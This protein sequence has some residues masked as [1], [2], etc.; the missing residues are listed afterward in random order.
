MCRSRAGALQHSTI[1]T[2]DRNAPCQW[3]QLNSR[4]STTAGTDRRCVGELAVKLGQTQPST[5][6]GQFHRYRKR[7]S[8]PTYLQGSS[9]FGFTGDEASD[10]YGRE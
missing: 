1:S 8:Q 6:A 4:D 7:S 9:Y 10:S 3:T 5:R 2:V